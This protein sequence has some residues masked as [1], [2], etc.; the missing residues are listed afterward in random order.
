MGKDLLLVG[1]LVMVY[2]ETNVPDKLAAGCVASCDC[3][4]CCCRCCCS[5]PARGKKKIERERIQFMENACKGNGRHD[6]RFG[7]E[8]S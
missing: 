8:K 2:H 4:W 3:C 1:G 5:S 6:A 7:M